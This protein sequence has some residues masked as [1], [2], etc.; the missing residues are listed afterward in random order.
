M[1]HQF[2]TILLD[3]LGGALA[4]DQKEYLSISLRN[5]NQLKCMIDDLLE[6]SR[7]DTAKLTVRRSSIS[8]CGVVAR[9]WRLTPSPPNKKRSH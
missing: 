5:V 3:G 2:T 6:A 9:R 8:L 1:V 7:A 4:K